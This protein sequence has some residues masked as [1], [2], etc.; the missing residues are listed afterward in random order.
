MDKRIGR[1]RF[2]KKVKEGVRRRVKQGQQCANVWG[3]ESSVLS[4]TVIEYPVARG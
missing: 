3:K 4:T 1:F 2:R